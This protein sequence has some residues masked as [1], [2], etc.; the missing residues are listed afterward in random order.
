MAL[1][2]AVSGLIL[3]FWPVVDVLNTLKVTLELVYGFMH[4]KIITSSLSSSLTTFIDRLQ[5]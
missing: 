4:M 2:F 1:I 5:V 3:V